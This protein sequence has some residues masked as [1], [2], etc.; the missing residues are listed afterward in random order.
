MFGQTVES[1]GDVVYVC[2][3]KINSWLD[4]Q[5]MAEAKK[6]FCYKVLASG[7]SHYTDYAQYYYS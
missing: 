5:L 4:F 3:Y 7:S 2:K 6:T 1:I